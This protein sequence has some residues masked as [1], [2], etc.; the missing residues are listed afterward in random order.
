MRASEAI[1]W[2]LRPWLD[3]GGSFA[4]IGR[5][6]VVSGLLLVVL[7]PSMLLYFGAHGWW[8]DNTLAVA[9]VAPLGVIALDALAGLVGLRG[10]P[11]V[12]S[13]CVG[14]LVGMLGGYLVTLA[15]GN[16]PD[17]TSA[18]ILADYRRTLGIVGPVL[19]V[20]TFLG[21]SLWYRGEAYRQQNAAA[22]A[23]FQVLRD[24]MQPHFLF[25]ALSAIKELIAEDPCRA[26][27]FVQQLADLYRA[28][29]KVANA[30]TSTLADELAVVASYCE[31]ERVRFG[32]RLRYRIEVDDDV[33]SL[34]V[35]SLMLQTLT[36]NAI[37]HG[38]GKSRTG[39]EICVRAERRGDGWLALE[40][41]NTGAPYV[42]AAD[43]GATGLANTRARL[44][45][46]YG[47]AGAFS[48]TA[49][50]KL[51]TCAR[52]AVSGAKVG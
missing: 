4:R 16:H 31:V 42:A 35:P 8:W 30:A 1:D 18:S 12:L 5:I 34:H 41:R 23:S 45:L 24:Q 21:A 38:I 29:M 17:R 10:V 9:L 26:R 39:G 48:I 13:L 51:G 49:D 52:F 14:A 32:D 3:G 2:V 28:I 22:L 36:E 27:E 25:N 7:V 47:P 15:L 50:T 11:R 40:V 33:R 44:A 46:M 20:G 37:K 6:A 19:A 43:S